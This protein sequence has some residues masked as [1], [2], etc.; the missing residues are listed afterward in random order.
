VIVSDRRHPEQSSSPEKVKGFFQ[1]L[2][3]IVNEAEIAPIPP[4]QS[5]NGPGDLPPYTP[6]YGQNLPP[7]QLHTSSSPEIDACQHPLHSQYHPDPY[8]QAPPPPECGY[9]PPY[10]TNSYQID[11]R[12]LLVHVPPTPVVTGDNFGITDLFVPTPR[13]TMLFV[14]GVPNFSGFETECGFRSQCTCTGNPH[15]PKIQHLRSLLQSQQ[16]LSPAVYTLTKKILTYFEGEGCPNNSLMRWFFSILLLVGGI[17]VLLAFAL[18]DHVDA[19]PVG[20]MASLLISVLGFWV[21]SMVS[22]CRRRSQKR[23]IEQ[24]L[25]MICTHMAA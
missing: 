6:P 24:E 1:G 18:S 3:M 14:N 25:A 17:G 12:P 22:I 16:C 21:R 20:L 23:E 7:Q 5:V 2:P 4:Y 13:G 8:C 19:L 10:Q 11:A 9:A 15:L